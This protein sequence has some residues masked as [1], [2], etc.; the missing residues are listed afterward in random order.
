MKT[1]RSWVI[2]IACFAAAFLF[3]STG[4]TYT[5]PVKRYGKEGFMQALNKLEDCL[6]KMEQHG[7][8]KKESRASV[9]RTANCN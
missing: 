8:F 6:D 4:S 9:N 3:M 2:R 7:S 5:E 1:R